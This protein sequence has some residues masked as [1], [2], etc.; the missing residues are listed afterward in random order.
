MHVR[1]IAA[2]QGTPSLSRRGYRKAKLFPLSHLSAAPACFRLL[3][4][5]LQV[6]PAIPRR[7]HLRGHHGS[8]TH[9]VL[10]RMLQ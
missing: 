7:R 3:T 4:G 6:G 2:R 1:E 9:L 10:D 5:D 8:I